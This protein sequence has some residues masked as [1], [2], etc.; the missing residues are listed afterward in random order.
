MAL[1]GKKPVITLKIDGMDCEHCVKSVTQA[2]QSVPDVK[3]VTVEIGK[4]VIVMKNDSFNKD[5]LIK[6]VEDAGYTVA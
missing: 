2:L 5:F 6:A 1:F 3:K 4:A